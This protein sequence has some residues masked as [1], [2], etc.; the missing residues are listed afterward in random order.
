MKSI[1]KAIK[2][3]VNAF[4]GNDLENYT[5]THVITDLTKVLE[6]LKEGFKKGDRKECGE[7]YLEIFR[8]R[9]YSERY[10]V[11]SLLGVEHNGGN[12][13]LRIT[14]PPSDWSL[15]QKIGNVGVFTTIA[16]YAAR[17]IIEQ[18]TEHNMWVLRGM[19][20]DLH[21]KKVEE[22]DEV[23]GRKSLNQLDVLTVRELRKDLVRNLRYENSSDSAINEYGFPS[24]GCYSIGVFDSYDGI[25]TASA[26][27]R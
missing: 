1:K 24:D 20:K 15:S 2:W 22:F 11:N 8:L 9:G 10:A 17:E 4:K 25:V 27:G 3:L 26:D 19:V 5:E 21:F 23:V 13:T 16:N 18:N 6:F 14:E 12:R 7:L